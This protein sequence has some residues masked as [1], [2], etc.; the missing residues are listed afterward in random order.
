MG[1]V[2]IGIA[3]ILCAACLIWQLIEADLA[4]DRF[5]EDHQG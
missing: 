3:V 1:P 2:I 4:E 5:A